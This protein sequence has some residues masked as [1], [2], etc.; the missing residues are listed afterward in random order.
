[1]RFFPLFKRKILPKN[2]DKAWE[3]RKGDAP[4]FNHSQNFLNQRG[5]RRELKEERV[6]FVGACRT[7]SPRK[8]Y[9]WEKDV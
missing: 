9:G 4:R 8:R 5:I 7:W 2:K 1:M 3:K 6:R